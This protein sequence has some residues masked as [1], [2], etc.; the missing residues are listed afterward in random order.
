MGSKF[1]HVIVGLS[2][3]LFFWVLIAK[4]QSSDAEYDKTVCA[5]PPLKTV[6]AR[7]AAME[8]GYSINRRYDCI[9]KDSFAEINRQRTAWQNARKNDQTTKANTQTTGNVRS[10]A[11]RPEQWQLM[12]V[13][14]I[15]NSY[16]DVDSLARSGNRVTVREKV[17]LFKPEHSLIANP[18]YEYKVFV[19]TIEYDCTANTSRSLKQINITASGEAKQSEMQVTDA[20]PLIGPY[21]ERSHELACSW[22]AKSISR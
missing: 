4:N 11:P 17:E 21:M 8:E 14:Q 20:M 22:N 3:G 13:S 9:D 6:E 7:N 19:S 5:E 18:P 10:E 16:R 15:G 1:V 12:F 2:I